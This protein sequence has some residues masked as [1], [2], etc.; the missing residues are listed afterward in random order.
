MR[1]QAKPVINAVSAVIARGST[2]KARHREA[3]L[4]RHIDVVAVQRDQELQARCVVRR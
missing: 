4:E 3:C 1:L 2:I